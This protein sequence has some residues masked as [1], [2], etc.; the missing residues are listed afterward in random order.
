[1]TR[2]KTKIGDVF[3][4]ELEDSLFGYGIITGDIFAGFYDFYSSQPAE[5]SEILESDVKYLLMFQDT[6]IERGDWKVI[7]NVPLEEKIHPPYKF[8]H[9]DIISGELSIRIVSDTEHSEQKSDLEECRDLEPDGIWSENHVHDRLVDEYYGRENIWVKDL[10][11][12]L[13]KI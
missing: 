2:I 3:Q 9:Q 13:D 10:A 7:G 8:C 5:L 6:A 4:I 12:D 11:I 1:M